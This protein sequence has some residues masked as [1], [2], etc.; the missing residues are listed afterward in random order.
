MLASTGCGSGETSPLVKTPAINASASDQRPGAEEATEA[1]AHTPTSVSISTFHASGPDAG[2]DPFFPQWNRGASQDALEAAP[3]PLFSYLKLVGVRPGT[4][5]P[6]ALINKT[7][8][9]PGEMGE[10]AVQITNQNRTV[11]QKI[12]VRCLEIRHDSVLISIAGEPGVKELRLAQN[13]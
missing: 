6:L 8:F 9:A 10:V 3:L 13:D 1:V 11:V 2:R 12:N 4:K 7:S 5:R